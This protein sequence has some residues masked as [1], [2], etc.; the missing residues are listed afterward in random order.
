MGYLNFNLRFCSKRSHVAYKWFPYF[1][2][3]GNSSLC[4]KGQP[5]DI[6]PNYFSLVYVLYSKIYV[7][8][9][10][11]CITNLF[12]KWP[13]GSDVTRQS[14]TDK[15]RTGI[16]RKFLGQTAASRF[17]RGCLTEKISL[18]S[19]A[20]KASRRRTGIVRLFRKVVF[21]CVGE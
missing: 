5:K 16:Q 20:A 18:N 15:G 19:F 13:R 8:R 4:Y 1:K 6:F 3:L 17:W 11:G 21:S 9:E 14:A 2:K 12:W 10:W 7:V